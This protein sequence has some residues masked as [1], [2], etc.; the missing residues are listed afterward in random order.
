MRRIWRRCEWGSSSLL[1]PQSRRCRDRPF[2]NEHG[3]PLAAAGDRQLRGRLWNLPTA[4]LTNDAAVVEITISVC[5]HVTEE[6][7][8]QSE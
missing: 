1:L 8:H 3:R 2:G 5:D 6:A 7:V 4:D